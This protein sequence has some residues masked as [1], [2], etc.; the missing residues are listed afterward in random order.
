VREWIGQYGDPTGKD[1]DTVVDWVERI[2]FTETRNYVMPGDGKL[3]DLQGATVGKQPRHRER[4][5]FR[6]ALGE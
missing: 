3:P 6:P 5:A 2:P 1:I 4:F